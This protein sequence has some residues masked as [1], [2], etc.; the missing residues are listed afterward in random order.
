[1]VIVDT[2]VWLRTL[3]QEDDAFKVRIQ[4]ETLLNNYLVAVTDSVRFDVLQ[5]IRSEQRADLFAYFNYLPN[6][7][8]K[9]STWNVAIQVSWDLSNAGIHLDQQEAITVAISLQNQMPLFT[10]NSKQKEVRGIRKL[11]LIE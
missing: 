5:S 7:P 9:P 6:F 4:L 11:K 10:L 2:S 1:M 8:V 3:G